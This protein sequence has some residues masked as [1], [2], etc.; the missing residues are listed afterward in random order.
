MLEN[1]LQRSFSYLNIK[2]S[3]FAGHYFGSMYDIR[4]S[5]KIS[6]F[7]DH[8]AKIA[9]L[10]LSYIEMGLHSGRYRS[11]RRNQNISTNTE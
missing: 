3:Y 2:K 6:F 10:E 7:S 1:L 9:E 8:M 4:T 5:L 11:V